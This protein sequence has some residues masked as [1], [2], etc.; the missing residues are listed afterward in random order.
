MREY[1]LQQLIAVEIRRD[2]CKIDQRAPGNG[3]ER[4]A[5]FRGILRN[6]N[7]HHKCR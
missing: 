1:L 7:E 2:I 4:P 5:Y 3:L 6:G